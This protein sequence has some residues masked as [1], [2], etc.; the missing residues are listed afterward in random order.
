MDSLGVDSLDAASGDGAF[1]TSSE[2][3]E[4]DDA[5]ADADGATDADADGDDDTLGDGDAVGD[6]VGDADADAVIDGDAETLGEGDARGTSLGAMAIHLAGIPSGMS[7]SEATEGCAK[8]SVDATT[9]SAAL[10]AAAPRHE[11]NRMTLP[12]P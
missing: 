9:D 1:V 11:R 3:D 2:V 5:D 8:R 6:A 12:L 7:D 10:T 4:D